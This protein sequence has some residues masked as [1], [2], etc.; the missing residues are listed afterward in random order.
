MSDPVSMQKW[1]FNAVAALLIIEGVVEIVNSIYKKD[2]T[3]IH[4]ARIWLRSLLMIVS[5]LIIFWLTQS[6]KVTVRINRP[7][8][9]LSPNNGLFRD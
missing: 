6:T 8:N 4:Q 2:Q 9:M 5:A 1:V 7:R 3:T